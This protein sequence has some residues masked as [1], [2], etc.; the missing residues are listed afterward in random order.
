M[1]T[2]DGRFSVLERDCGESLWDYVSVK[3]IKRSFSLPLTPTP[4]KAIFTL[5]S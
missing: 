1:R 2:E 4:H 3:A 5:S